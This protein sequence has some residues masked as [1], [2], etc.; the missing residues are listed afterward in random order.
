M[1]GADVRAAFAA[2]TAV[3]YWHSVNAHAQHVLL[4]IPRRARKRAG[5][6]TVSGGALVSFLLKILPTVPSMNEGWSR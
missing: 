5:L 4:Q 2:V 1:G 3:N 6:R